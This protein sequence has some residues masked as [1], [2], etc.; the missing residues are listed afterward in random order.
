MENKKP[1]SREK[2]R[3]KI[4]RHILTHAVRKFI[5]RLAAKMLASNFIAFT[6]PFVTVGVLGL[7]IQ[8]APWVFRSG[9]TDIDPLP[10]LLFAFLSGF[11]S[12]Y[13]RY[14]IMKKFSYI[15]P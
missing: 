10:I 15:R 6:V 13:L 14:R 8:L 2:A 1:F 12:F 4:N 9:V 11:V 3:G 7:L 5:F